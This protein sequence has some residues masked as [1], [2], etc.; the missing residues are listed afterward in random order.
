MRLFTQAFC[1][2]LSRG[3]F[4]SQN[5]NTSFDN[6]TYKLLAAPK[7]SQEE[8][9][10]EQDSP[11]HKPRHKKSLASLGRL[12]HFNQSQSSQNQPGQ[13]GLSSRDTHQ[14]SLQTGRYQS[15]SP[16]SSYQ[17]LRRSPKEGFGLPEDDRDYQDDSEDECGPGDKDEPEPTVL[18][19][20][21]YHNFLCGTSGRKTKIT[22]SSISP[23]QPDAS[24]PK[25]GFNLDARHLDSGAPQTV[26]RTKPS[27]KA[28]VLVPS[29]KI[30]LQNP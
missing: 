27:K 8:R 22:L 4:C 5:P 29:D 21:D 26:I 25:Q 3:I 11:H 2:T 18:G 12:F 1:K 9:W 20:V 24:T 13:P 14:H 7:D 17:Q 10:T 30:P 19:S 6:L 16:K 23:T 15:L 28:L